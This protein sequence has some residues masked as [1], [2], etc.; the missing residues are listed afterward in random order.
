M[1]GSAKIGARQGRP[2]GGKAVSWRAVAVAVAEHAPAFFSSFWKVVKGRAFGARSIA[3]GE[4]GDEGVLVVDSLLQCGCRLARRRPAR[5]AR[6]APARRRRGATEPRPGRLAARR[7][8]AASGG[9]SAGERR[10][11]RACRSSSEISRS[12]DSGRLKPK[13]RRRRS[14][15]PESGDLVM[16]ASTT[17]AGARASMQ[18]ASMSWMTSRPSRSRRSCARAGGGRAA[19]AAPSPPK[20][21]ASKREQA[22]RRRNSVRSSCWRSTADVRAALDSRSCCS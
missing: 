9:W 17:S 2:A 6:A 10:S 21:R 11:A 18:S 14:A 15:R 20:R 4:P 13:R 5:R 8:R 22:R 12:G 19:E 16:W 7:A 1:S 3:R